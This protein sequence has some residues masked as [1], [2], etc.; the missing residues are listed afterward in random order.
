MSDRYIMICHDSPPPAAGEPCMNIGYELHAHSWYA[1][2]AHLGYGDWS[3]V[4]G[5][6]GALWAFVF[7]SRLILRM[8]T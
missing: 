4:A 1:S 8:L 7:V 6:I 5:A 2:V 3:M